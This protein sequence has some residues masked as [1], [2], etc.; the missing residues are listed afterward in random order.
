MNRKAALEMSMNSIVVI[1]LAVV[2]V[3]IVITF[4]TSV[5]ETQEEQVL[6]IIS[7]FP[8]IDPPTRDEPFKI[9]K[10]NLEISRADSDF[11]VIEAYYRHTGTSGAECRL[12]DISESNKLE[13]TYSTNPVPIDFD[14]TRTVKLGIRADQDAPAAD[15]VGPTYATIKV[16]C[17]K[18][19]ESSVDVRSDNLPSGTSGENCGP[20]AFE[21]SL[22]LTI[23]IVE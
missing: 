10:S 14:D 1:I 11:Q 20:D 12:A 17:A 6:G 2:F 9:P 18:D 23:N 19:D 4:I 15:L 13:I 5:F 22:S 8:N 3:S 7:D 21:K 16:C